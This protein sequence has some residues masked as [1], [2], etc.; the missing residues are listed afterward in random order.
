MSPAEVTSD[1]IVLRDA[2]RQF[3]ADREWAGYHDPKSL[4]LALVAEVGELSEIFQWLPAAEA[5]R[6]VQQS[7]LREQTGAEIADVLLYLVR[8]ADVLG[9]DVMRATTDKMGKNELKHRPGDSPRGTQG[10][11]RPKSPT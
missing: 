7:P 4:I 8:L 11:L 6:L 2:M 10:A 5:A 1:L 9:I 3:T